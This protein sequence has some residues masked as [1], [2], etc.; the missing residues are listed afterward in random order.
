P[1]IWW[2]RYTNAMGRLILNTLEVTDIPAVLCAAAEDLEDS[3]RRLP[4]LLE[5]LPSLTSLPVA[6]EP[7]A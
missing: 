4:D 1:G 7:A 3:R 6:E 5:E 2:V